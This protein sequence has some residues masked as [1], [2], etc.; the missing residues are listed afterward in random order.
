MTA[1]STQY[2][3]IFELGCH[4]CGLQ[5]THLT[6]AGQICAREVTRE[7]KWNIVLGRPLE[8]R[9]SAWEAKVG[10]VAVVSGPGV[11]LQKAPL[12][13]AQELRPHEQVLRDTFP[14]VG[15]LG[16]VSIMIL[17]DL[18][19]PPHLSMAVR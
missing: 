4:V 14:F 3:A 9:R 2:T 13:S 15:G 7:K 5:E 17:A 11:D 12:T 1:F 10:G 16:A 8:S 19:V 6:E 18:N